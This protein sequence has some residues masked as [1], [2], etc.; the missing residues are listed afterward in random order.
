MLPQQVSNEEATYYL[1]PSAGGAPSLSGYINSPELAQHSAGLGDAREYLMVQNGANDAV[2][3]FDTNYYLDP[4]MNQH[5]SDEPDLGAYVRQL[6][7]FERQHAQSGGA[8]DYEVG[9][10]FEAS[11]Q[12]DLSTFAGHDQ[13]Y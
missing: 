1:S 11:G 5:E 12:H 7:G 9:L 2:E 4:G 13:Y 3:P 10:G 6:E 8:H